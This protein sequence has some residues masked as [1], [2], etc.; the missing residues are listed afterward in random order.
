MAHFYGTVQGQAR[1]K[2]TRCGSRSS[3]LKTIAASW[4]GAV[5]VELWTQDGEDY[6]RVALRRWNGEGTSRELYF[7]PVG[8]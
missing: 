7:G 8:S 1:T 2:A 5:E 4:R 6:V 3:G